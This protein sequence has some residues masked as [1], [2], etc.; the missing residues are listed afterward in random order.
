MSAPTPP[1]RMV[2]ELA[3]EEHPRLYDDLARFPKGPKRLNRLRTLA[4]DGLLVQHGWGTPPS[5]SDQACQPTARTSN[6]LIGQIFEEPL[7]E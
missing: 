2:L 1:L 6:S 3:R 4:H 5:F 7:E